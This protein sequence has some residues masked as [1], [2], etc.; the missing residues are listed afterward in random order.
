MLAK[1][2]VQ[3]LDTTN[4]LTNEDTSK[5]IKALMTRRKKP[6]VS[7]VSGKVMTMSNGLTM[8]F[9]KPNNS[10][11]K[12]NEEVVANRMPPKSR[13]AAHSDTAVMAQC[14]KNGVMLSSI[15]DGSRRYFDRWI[16][17][18]TAP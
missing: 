11:E 14:R 10:A 12:I 17:D 15:W 2:A 7:K 13:L 3:K 4:P 8:A 1:N 18:D 6:N 5:T 16:C 9:A